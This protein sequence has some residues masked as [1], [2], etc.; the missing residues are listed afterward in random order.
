MGLDHWHVLV[1]LMPLK[2][3]NLFSWRRSMHLRRLVRVS[4]LL[5]Y[6]VVPGGLWAQVAGGVELFGSLDNSYAVT[7][8]LG[9][10]SLSVGTPYVGIR[11]SGGLGVSSPAT[12]VGFNQGPS[13]LAWAANADLVLGP[14]NAGLGEG[15]MPYT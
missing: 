12:Q 7:R 10:L 4:G 13:N 15:F 5:S 2:G 3:V 14:V 6:L 9:G 8:T 11:G 1:P